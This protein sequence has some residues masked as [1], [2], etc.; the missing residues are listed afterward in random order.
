[1]LSFDDHG[2]RVWRVVDHSEALQRCAP[3]FYQANRRFPTTENR[4]RMLGGISAALPPSAGLPSSEAKG[5]GGG[6][7]YT[8]HH[9][10]T[11]GK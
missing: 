10:R 11:I 1:M 5:V 2:A 7:A 3:P 8:L 4:P 6:Q 9:V